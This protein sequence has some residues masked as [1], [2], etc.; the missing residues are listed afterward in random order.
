M[1]AT[2]YAVLLTARRPA[3]AWQTLAAVAAWVLTL[4]GAGGTVWGQTVTPSL[5]A[6]YEAARDRFQYR[7][8]NPSTFDTA[9]PVP[10][11]FTQ[12]YVG[13]NHWA[14]L[15]ARFPIGGRPLESE[16]G[17]TPQRTTRGDDFDTFFQPGGDIV[18]AGTTGNVSL[19]SLRF[20]QRV[21]LGK[22]AGLSWHVGYRYQRDRSIFHPATKI[23][24]H[25]RP[26]SIDVTIVSTRE[27]TISETHDVGFGAAKQWRM[28]DRWRM[29]LGVEITPATHARLTVQLPDKYPKRDLVFSAL[30]L[31]LAPSVTITRDTR[32]P[33]SV[34]LEGIRTSSYADARQFQ[35]HSIA[36]AA[37]ITLKK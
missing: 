19:R 6:G 21:G 12:I 35:R 11:E 34:T 15:T 36:F 23:V 37:D 5:S 29:D 32:W 14:T 1:D 27:T 9:E 16:A 22:M 20:R 18:V 8:E 3:P 7:F 13:D 28:R 26:S 31:M 30:V 17:F 24:T 33:I 4:A 2:P 10:H 25:T